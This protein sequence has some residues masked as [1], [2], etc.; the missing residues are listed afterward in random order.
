MIGG[1]YEVGAQ[2]RRDVANDRKF[3]NDVQIPFDDIAVVVLLLP[4][5]SPLHG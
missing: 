2:E 3:P 5:L 4:I 1:R